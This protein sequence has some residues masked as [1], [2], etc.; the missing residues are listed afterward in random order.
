MKSVT[1]IL[2]RVFP[3]DN[4]IPE[5]VLENARKRGSAVHEWIEAYNKYL[6][7]GGEEPTI[8]FEYLIYADSYKK[9]VKEYQVKPKHTELKLSDDGV[10]GII[11]MICETKEDPEIVVDFKITYDYN[12]PYVELQTSA[13]KHLGVANKVVSPNVP[14]ALLHI[15]KNGFNYVKLN[16]E[17]EKFKLIKELDDYIDRRSKEKK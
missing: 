5:A 15:S 12:L 17:Y 9:W 7:D 2:S 1:K 14:Q 3:M 13:Y 8:N 4:K 11:D 16:D 6:V 10:V